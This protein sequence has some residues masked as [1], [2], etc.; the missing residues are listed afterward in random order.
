MALFVDLCFLPVL[1]KFVI[2]TPMRKVGLVFSII[3]EEVVPVHIKEVSSLIIKSVLSRQGS[4][5]SQRSPQNHL[6]KEV[7]PIGI[8]LE[9]IKVCKRFSRYAEAEMMN[10]RD[11]A[12]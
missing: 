2:A 11:F 5:S 10:K 7:D 1:E 8:Y 4:C 9:G 3:S 6:A 12:K